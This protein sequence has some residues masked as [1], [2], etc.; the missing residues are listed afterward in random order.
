MHF[1]SSAAIWFQPQPSTTDWP[2]GPSGV[3]SSDF[4]ALFQSNAPWMN[5]AAHTQTF[6]LYAPWVTAV[7][8]QVLQQ[9]VAFI[10]AHNMSIELE[11][12]ALQATVLCGTGVEGYVPWGQSLHNFTLAYLQRLKSLGT[13]VLFVKV[14]EPYYFGSIVSDPRACHLQVADV[15]SQ[16]WQYAQLVKSVYPNA[17]IG[18]IEPIIA[19]AYGTDVVSAIDQWHDT[20]LTVSGTAFP[21]FFADTDFSDPMWP[22]IVKDLEGETR[23]RGIQFGIIYTGDEQDTSD[24]EW[25]SKVAARFQTYQGEN[26]GQPDYVLFQSWEPHP[27]LCLPETDPTTFTGVIDAYIGAT[28]P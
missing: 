2:G 20:Y 4:L 28:T 9:T 26:G 16:V 14:D 11:A 24:A 3:G 10:K 6:G 19:N 13:Q 21:F 25:T 12:P 22:S 7:S 18:D 1:T 5:A 15:A 27:K 23:Q 17:Q 8:D